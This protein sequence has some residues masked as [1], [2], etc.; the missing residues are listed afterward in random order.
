MYR[1]SEIHS[2]NISAYIL[3]Y[4]PLHPRYQ[5]SSLRLS[6]RG[7]F[8]ARRLLRP[9]YLPDDLKDYEINDINDI[10]FESIY[11]SFFLLR[12]CMDSAYAKMSRDVGEIGPS[13]QEIRPRSQNIERSRRMLSFSHFVCLRIY[14][15]FIS[16]PIP[17]HTLSIS[18]FFHFDF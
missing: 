18:F 9:R 2:W 13:D 3:K 14:H 7:E 17:R 16:G 15:H 4:P 6:I 12:F 11:N 10:F 1:A 5:R 8:L